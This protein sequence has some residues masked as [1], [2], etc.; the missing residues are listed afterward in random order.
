MSILAVY[1]AV[2]YMPITPELGKLM[3]E[4]EFEACLN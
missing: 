4:S 3:Q 2:W 1:I